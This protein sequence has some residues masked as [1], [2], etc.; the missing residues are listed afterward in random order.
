MFWVRAG[1]VTKFKDSYS[2]IAHTVGI[3][4]SDEPES[5]A[6]LPSL[7]RSWLRNKRKGRWLIILDGAD[8]MGVFYPG[9]S[10][11][12]DSSAPRFL[13]WLPRVAH[14][15]ILITTRNRGVAINLIGSQ[16]ESSA[17]YTIDSMNL[18]QAIQ[19]LKSRVPEPLWDDEIA[20]E[21]V[22][23][24]DYIPLAIGHAAAYIDYTADLLCEYLDKIRALRA[25]PMPTN[26]IHDS[27]RD[28]EASA[29]VFATWRLSLDQIRASS[30][31]AA[32]LLCL[33]STFDNQNIPEFFIARPMALGYIDS[34]GEIDPVAQKYIQKYGTTAEEEER[35]PPRT[36]ATD[37][38]ERGEVGGPG[39]R[40]QNSNLSE[41]LVQSDQRLRDDISLLYNY[42]MISIDK[43]R[44]PVTY[45]MH[46]LVQSAVTRWLEAGDDR[47]AYTLQ[48]YRDRALIEVSMAF[49][50]DGASD[51]YE[52][53]ALHQNAAKVLQYKVN[54]NVLGLHHA[55]ILYHQARYR[56]ANQEP[57][58]AEECI[59]QTIAIRRSYSAGYTLPV[60]K[61]LELHGDICYAVGEH[62]R[63]VD[64]YR[65][66]LEGWS[67]SMGF[68]PDLRDR[69]RVNL[70]ASLGQIHRSGEGIE[71]LHEAIRSSLT[72]MG[73]DSYSVLED[74][75]VLAG[76]HLEKG[77]TDRA[78]DE[79][80]AVVAAWESH[81]AFERDEFECM[82]LARVELIVALRRAGRR[83]EAA[84]LAESAIPVAQAELGVSHPTA[85]RLQGSFASVLCALGRLE[86]AE[87]VYRERH[88]QCRLTMAPSHPYRQDALL[89]TVLILS[90]QSKDT[91]IVALVDEEPAGLGSPPAEA[92][93]ERDYWRCMMLYAYGRQMEGKTTNARAVC[94]AALG[95]LGELSAHKDYEF[96]SVF[97]LKLATRLCRLELY[98][99][100][101]SYLNKVREWCEWREG[102]EDMKREYAETRE[103]AMDG[104]KKGAD[105]T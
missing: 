55:E 83:D 25:P 69:L 48:E 105:G 60:I 2:V 46:G 32:E 85:L 97:E 10:G 38:L 91:D 14:G 3:A 104:L 72:R 59:K 24:L 99:E 8:D 77:D 12:E 16:R 36:D 15:S 57:Q 93:V 42:H 62:A 95:R 47:T 34:L 6:N 82:T 41:W 28:E 40:Q 87:A 64:I 71:L 68:S 65:D 92:V 29:S 80:R 89:H 63:A 45:S 11:G 49:K 88:V 35:A 79:L 23:E 1:T 53:A 58:R 86:E 61:A 51:I 21:I 39:L 19:L 67:L 22:K 100:S 102:G 52:A 33:M 37:S 73:A 50:L 101:I 9:D 75:R 70:G 31:T 56:L 44:S 98:E 103:K 27:R 81:E 94:Q 30:E 96:V 43:T 20:G 78:I 84:R 74:Q 18:K 54:R 13:Q 66:A 5:S 26:E 4:S 90:A 76:L 17:I 7:A